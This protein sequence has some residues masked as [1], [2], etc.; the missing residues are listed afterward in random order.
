MI[1]QN[2]GGA[3]RSDDLDI[4]KLIHRRAASAGRFLPTA[5]FNWFRYSSQAEFAAMLIRPL[6]NGFRIS[7]TL[8][9]KDAGRERVGRVAG[10]HR[11]ALL[12]KDFP[13]IVLIIDV[14]N[15]A[16]AHGRPGFENRF[17]NVMA[18]HPFAA[19]RGQ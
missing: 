2:R 9:G 11:N 15:G 13:V 6:A 14:V 8:G 7:F 18:I 5:G 3:Q 19:E 10:Q 16:T 1:S 4:G 12:H 17:V